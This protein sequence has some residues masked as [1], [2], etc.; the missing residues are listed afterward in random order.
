[1]N[2]RKFAAY[3]MPVLAAVPAVLQAQAASQSGGLEE[4]IVTAERREASLQTVPIAVTALTQVDLENRQM[5][6]P[7]DL[8]LMVPSLK[9]TY[10]ITSPTNL[11]PSL[12]GSTQQDASA[13]AAESP[14]GMY[15]DDIYV[16]RLNG[17]NVG[18][19]DLQSVEVLRG[20][21]GTLYGRN[22]LSGALKFTSRTPGKDS[23]LTANAGVGDNDQYRAGFSMGGPLS[24]AWAASLSATYN[25][26]DNE[27][28][29]IA[30]NTDQGLEENLAMRAKVHFMPGNGFDGVAFIS[31]VDSK[32]DAMAM[33]PGTTPGVASNHH[34]ESNDVRPTFGYYTLATQP[35]TV[36]IPNM[37]ATP[38]G[39]TKQTI[40]GVNL[41]YD[42]GGPT[43]QSITGFVNTKD[44]FTNDFSGYGLIEA[45]SDIN[46]D[47][48]SEELQVHGNAFGDR[49]AYFGGVYYLNETASQDWGWY[50]FGPASTSKVKIKTESISAFGQA[51]FKI[52]DALS[53]TLG[54]RW[55]QDDKNFD[56]S[57]VQF[58]P[59]GGY[60]DPVSLHNT[61]SEW[62]P[63]FALDYTV[64]A[65]ASVDS[66]LL[67]ASV[68]KGFK[69]GGYNGINITD[70]SNAQTPYGPESNWTYEIGAK[71]DLFGHRLR[72]NAAYFY[73]KATELALNATV[74]VN[75]IPTFPVQNVGDATIQGLELEITAAVTDGLTVFWN[76]SFLSGKYT[77]LDPTSA[78]AQSVALYGVKEPKVPQLPSMAFSLG[79]DYHRDI[80]LG[81]QGGRFL[82]GMDYF[83]SESYVVA[84]TND[85]SISPYDRMNGYLAVEFAKSW[86]LRLSGRNLQNRESINSGSRALGGFIMLPPRE[87]MLSVGYKK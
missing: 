57:I 34:F 12:R 70:L 25:H 17:N 33:I 66:M 68:A 36:S 78:P 44:T 67:Y 27:W 53:T 79:F 85:W 26:K 15:V 29:N 46:A 77:R 31:Y 11:S 30:T 7:Q 22:T 64:P 18:F 56:T 19:G 54:V 74:I 69:S 63:K 21:Q 20:P 41:S 72:L 49:L 16:G 24:D 6:A 62:T 50:F 48:F 39:K 9:M 28:H 60:T 51:D 61:Y 4:V 10:N 35:L 58:V 86:E 87:I 23:W 52:T 83:R 45:G 5:S 71:S 81:S 13:I 3:F 2:S 8:A 37:A 59:F 38:Q 47:Q 55:T 43:I 82:A 80:P 75:D 40:A 42:L 32:N 65:S 73:E 84:P 14:F 1:M 76:P